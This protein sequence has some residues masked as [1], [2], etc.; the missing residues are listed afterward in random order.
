MSKLV[1]NSNSIG[2]K[3][4]AIGEYKH[5]K[6]KKNICCIGIQ[7]TNRTFIWLRFIPKYQIKH[8]GDIASK[9]P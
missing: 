2:N 3:K 8:I 4:E 7:V 6:W 5:S 9:F 1:L